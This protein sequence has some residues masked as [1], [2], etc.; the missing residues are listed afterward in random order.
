[1]S[2]PHARRSFR[3]WLQQVHLWSGLILC[4][5]LV[6]LGLT[7]SVLVFHHEIEE[8]TSAPLPA[9]TAGTPQSAAALVAAAS[10]H[11]PAEF[12]A[13]AITFP[14]HA[15]DYAQIRFAKP[16]PRGSGPPGRGPGQTVLVDPVSLAIV[17]RETP[18]SN[19]L[20][21]TFH[22]LHGNLMIE[23]RLGRQIVGALGVVMLV[24]GVSGLIMWWPR[25]GQWRTAFSVAKGARGFRLHRD[26]HGAVG[27]WSLIVFTVV[28][29]TG[30]YIAFPETVGGGVRAV[31]PGR[32]L[33]ASAN[34]LTVEPADGVTPLG[35]DG[36]ILL[37]QEAAPGQ[38][39]ATLM[40]S[41]RPN[42]PA[43]V[44]LR[45]APGDEG[46]ALT[47]VYI[48]PW[49]ARVIEKRDPRDYTIGETI[50]AWQR[51]L[52]EGSGLGWGWKILVFLS[53]LLPLLFSI[54]GISM[55]L[56]K[57]HRRPARARRAGAPA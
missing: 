31:F 2:T 42:Q 24:L 1:M 33:R 8:W 54:T 55:W 20:M 21:R 6:L 36:L 38:D 50:L 39:P 25:K 56:L 5:P 46:P 11:V 45:R 29:F 22:V 41:Q 13:A 14:E 34:A 40:L 52:H 53:G 27:F 48:D 26:L 37:A 23:G 49:R 10:S 43:R 4:V 19:T 51:A 28:S 15:G 9:A 17:N 35:I 7:G 16:G 3:Y 44:T 57:R 30:V 32:D 18:A 47:T 12:A